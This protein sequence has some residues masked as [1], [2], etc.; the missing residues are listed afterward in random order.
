MK[1]ESFLALKYIKSKKT[2]RFISFS[3]FISIAGIILGVAALII[4]MGVMNGFDNELEQKIIGVN[5]HVFIKN[6]SGVFEYNPVFVKKIKNLSGVKYV[7]PLLTMQC[8]VSSDRF[9]SGGILNG[10]K[11]ANSGE[12]KKYIKG[13]TDGVVVGS[14]LLKIIGLRVGDK[15]RITLPFGKVTP[16]GF[17]PLSFVAKITGI[18]KSGMYDYDTTFVYIPIKELWAKTEMKNKINTIAIILKD[19]YRAKQFSNML[20]KYLKP[21]FYASN[22]IDLNS[23]FF[24]ALKLEKLA[25]FVILMLV[26]LVA[27]FNITSSL[28]MLAMEKVK[29]MAVLMAF[30][31]TKRNIKNI[32]LKQA[33]IIG[34]VGVLLGD[35]LGLLLS[36]LLSKYHFIKL[37][38]SVYYINTIPVDI[39]FTYVAVISIS[40]FLLVILASLYP[41]KKAAGVDIVEVLRQ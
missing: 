4:V 40:A 18:F 1:F 26:I 36:F 25:M 17:A 20:V 29:D 22:W 33:A 35:F 34:A 2:E 23:N 32:F 7:Y 12:L 31:A 37:P 27:A 38:S 3:S 13:K 11:I 39:G 41:A 10:V 6:F 16:F 5:P 24:S 15:I 19:P 9:S 21:G 28:M 8:I 14:E 30:G